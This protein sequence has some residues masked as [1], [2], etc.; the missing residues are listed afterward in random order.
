MSRLDEITLKH[1]SYLRLYEKVSRDEVK[2]KRNA[3]LQ[4][5]LFFLF[6]E[7]FEIIGIF[8]NRTLQ[9][10]LHRYKWLLVFYVKA[11]RYSC[12]KIYNLKDISILISWNVMQES[13]GEHDHKYIASRFPRISYVEFCKIN[14]EISFKLNIFRHQYT[15]CLCTENEKK[16]CQSIDRKI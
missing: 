3:L 6:K 15:S 12:R 16:M 11:L 9:T 7:D 5:V 1:L 2:R 13:Q 14:V 8:Q 4:L 10:F